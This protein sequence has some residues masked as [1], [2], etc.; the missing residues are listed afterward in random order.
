MVTFLS[1]RARLWSARM[2]RKTGLSGRACGLAVEAGRSTATST[3]ARGAATMKMISSTSMTSMKGVTLISWLSTSSSSM[4]YRRSAMGLL[5][6]PGRCCGC[7]RLAPIAV[8]RDQ[9]QYLGRSVGHQGFMGGDRPGE[10]VVDD[11]GRNCRDQPQRCCQE[12]FRDAG[13]DDGEIGGLGFRDADEA[14]H[15]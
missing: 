5:G 8:A 3:V 6:R 7:C 4:E 2:E 13:R 1:P 14:V 10:V 9:A 12:G 15:D 11:H